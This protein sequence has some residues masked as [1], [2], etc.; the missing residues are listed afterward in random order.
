[1]SMFQDK[2]PVF[3]VNLTVQII[4]WKSTVILK[5]YLFIDMYVYQIWMCKKGNV[6]RL[7]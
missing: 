4:V 7:S 1:M 3:E 2:V 5:E 6:Y